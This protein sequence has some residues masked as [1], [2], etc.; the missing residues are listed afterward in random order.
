MQ[1][2]PDENT[3]QFIQ[4]QVASGQFANE[5]AVLNASIKLMRAREE[6]VAALREHLQGALDEDIWY[7]ADEVRTYLDQDES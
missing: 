1:Y 2:T 3:Q 5:E 4:Q 7:S 6:K